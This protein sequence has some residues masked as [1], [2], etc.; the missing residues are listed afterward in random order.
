MSDTD[1]GKQGGAARLFAEFETLDEEGRRGRLAMLTPESAGVA[2]AELIVF[3]VEIMGDASWRVRK[4]A[5]QKMASL[6]VTFQAARAL[7]DALAE[8]TNIGRRNAAVEGLVA[9]GDGALPPLIAALRERPEHR[10]LLVDTLGLLRDQ[11]A[12][13]PL[14]PLLSDDDANVRIAAAEALGQLGGTTAADGLRRAF[15]DG[16]GLLRLAALDG[17]NRAH[18]ALTAAELHSALLDP[19]LRAAACEALGRS[20]DRRAVNTLADALADGSRSVREGA[21]RGVGHLLA[22]AAPG[23][24]Q[25]EL[26][27]ALRERLRRLG[28]LDDIAV[29]LDLGSLEVQRA[30]AMVLGF[31]GRPEAVAPLVEALSDR[32]LAREVTD[33]LLALGDTAV[34]PLLELLPDLEERERADAIVLLPRLVS[35][36]GAPHPTVLSYL[37][38]ALAEDD[39]ATAAAAAAALGQLGS[40]E[41]LPLVWRAL[42]REPEVAEAATEALARI[43][44][45]HPDDV[46]VLVRSKGL[47]GPEGPYLC[48]VLGRLGALAGSAREGDVALLKGALGGGEARLRRA[49]AEAL[50]ELPGTSEIDD[51]LAFT[52]ADEGAEVRAA[53]ARALGMHGRTTALAAL[54]RATRDPERKVRAAAARALA[55]IAALTPVHEAARADVLE[56]LRRVANDSDVVVTAPALE[57]LGAHGDPADVERLRGQLARLS[58]ATDSQLRQVLEAALAG[59]GGH[60]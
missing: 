50:G 31:T 26:I 11:R 44:A 32:E 60:G 29:A 33:A 56:A 55:Q 5:A 46:H 42:G 1:V 48:R 3:L 2:A 57:A 37:E 7:T 21:L 36:S 34:E 40:R 18:V 27:A 28:P 30:A 39:P 24:E 13:E 12:A 8:P 25:T 38:G 14:V 6:P 16:D 10:K 20:G 59:R 15:T 51:T 54:E 49:A 52:L 22:G 58:R 19:T 47:L 23:S 35:T 41:V 17:L 43:G 9:L 45:H 53:A 4:E